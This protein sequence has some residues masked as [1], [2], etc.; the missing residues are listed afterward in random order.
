MLSRLFDNTLRNGVQHHQ[1]LHYRCHEVHLAAAI[2]DL[3]YT[4]HQATPI[5]VSNS[6]SYE[7]ALTKPAVAAAK[8]KTAVLQAPILRVQTVIYV[9]KYRAGAI[10]KIDF[11]DTSYNP[12]PPS[13]TVVEPSLDTRGDT[14]H[15]LPILGIM[16]K[17]TL[18]EYSKV[19]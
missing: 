2:R 8:E 4:L 7:S 1:P 13:K 9:A 11:D 17:P 6:K 5:V 16:T 19:H 14:E 18:R 10:V 3:V 15:V 12:Q